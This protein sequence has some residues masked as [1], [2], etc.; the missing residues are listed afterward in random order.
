MALLVLI[1]TSVAGVSLRAA[2][3][4]MAFMCGPPSARLLAATSVATR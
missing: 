3:R 1:Q 2:L 4:S